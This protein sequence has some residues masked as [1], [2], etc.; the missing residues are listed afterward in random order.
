MQENKA[1]HPAAAPAQTEADPF[2]LARLRLD[3]SFLETAGVK[4]L[5]TT[6]PVG[7]PHPQDFVRVHR[8]P[9]YR[10]SFATI[11]WK[12]D[13]EF[14]LVDPS[15]ARELPGECIGVELFT[16]VNR[17]GVIR[18]WPV[19]LPGPDG[20]VIEWHRSLAEA[21][22]RAVERWVRVKANRSLGAYEIFEASASI[23]DAEWPAETFQQLIRIGFRDRLIDRLDHPLIAKL[24]GQ[25]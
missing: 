21:A 1:T 19:K 24:R 5:L 17:Q 4:K 14:F 11:E 25:A 20:R 13:R 16:C 9:A 8:D 10:G 22:E 7:K 6:V 15:V 3:P 12:E 2:D 23:P 18:L